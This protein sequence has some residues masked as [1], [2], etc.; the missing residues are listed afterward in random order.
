MIIRV[1]ESVGVVGLKGKKETDEK[2][3]EESQGGKQFVGNTAEAKE[4]RRR[5]VEGN[6]EKVRQNGEAV[7]KRTTKN[8]E[9]T[10]VK[11]GGAGTKRSEKQSAKPKK[12][13]EDSSRMQNLRKRT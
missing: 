6:S 2:K 13:T 7:E 10:D 4:A 8:E 12:E 5:K 9:K 3:T 11:K 1:N